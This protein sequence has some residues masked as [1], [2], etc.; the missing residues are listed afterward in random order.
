MSGTAR[1]ILRAYPPSFRARY[2]A[3]LAALLDELPAG[4]RTTLDLARGAAR[5]WISPR[6]TGPDARRL[7]LQAS[8]STTWAAWCAG[9]LVVP[10]MSK[11]LLDPPGPA[12]SA[13]VRGLLH[14]GSAIL[15]AGWIPALIGVATILIRALIP[16]LRS[17]PGRLLRPLL[18]AVVLGALVAAG[19]A[20][21]AALVPAAPGDQLMLS[22]FL[23][24]LCAVIGFLVALGLGLGASL[25]RL[26]APAALLRLPA[27][28]AVALAIAMALMCACSLASVAL[29]GDATLFDSFVPVA[30]VLTV[31]AAAAVTALVS[32]AR[33]LRAARG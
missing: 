2:G 4:R 19:L 22:V 26:K 23:A 5:A 6:F 18:P 29:S 31:A 25:R 24:W 14:A 33:G 30:I 1:A 8:V 21:L 27:R 15:V 10:A 32:S 7:R 17:R 12:S 13:L 28:L 11:A 3:E 9:S 16:A 20:V